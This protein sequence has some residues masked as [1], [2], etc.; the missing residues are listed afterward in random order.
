MYLGEEE[1]WNDDVEY[2]Q[3]IENFVLGQEDIEM[4]GDKTAETSLKNLN[5][6]KKDGGSEK[7][8]GHDG[9]RR[10]EIVKENEEIAAICSAENMYRDVANSNEERHEMFGVGLEESLK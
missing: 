9:E 3:C 6:D 10:L 1:H 2:E 7:T 5:D 8:E 4:K